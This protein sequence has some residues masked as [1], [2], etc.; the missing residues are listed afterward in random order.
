MAF[1]KQI[2][3]E[4]KLESQ[5]LKAY[6][7]ISFELDILA[8][9]LKGAYIQSHIT[10]AKVRIRLTPA[11]RRAYMIGLVSAAISKISSGL[12]VRL[13]QDAITASKALAKSE[14]S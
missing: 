7:F 5:H 6:D 14:K 1:N 11:K 13:T 3:L 4:A 12:I 8:V 2:R 9:Q 10:I